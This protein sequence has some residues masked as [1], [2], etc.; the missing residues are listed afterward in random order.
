MTAAG[1]VTTASTAIEHLVAE[2]L[3][4]QRGVVRAS[5]RAFRRAGLD[6]ASDEDRVIA[7]LDRRL[8]PALDECG[9]VGEDWRARRARAKRLTR[10]RV[11]FQLRRL[12]ERERDG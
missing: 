5:V 9:R 10:D 1:S 2:V 7:F 12:E 3:Q 8:Q 4:P 6:H 11:A